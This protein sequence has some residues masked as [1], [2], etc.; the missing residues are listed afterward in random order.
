MSHP[1]TWRGH[2][3]PAACLQTRFTSRKLSH[4]P[5]SYTVIG[6]ET[7]IV[8]KL[9]HERELCLFE[10]VFSWVGQQSHDSPAASP[11]RPFIAS[12]PSP[13]AMSQDM[14]GLASSVFLH[15]QS[16]TVITT[17]CC[18]CCFLDELSASVVCWHLAGNKAKKK[19]GNQRWGGGGY[20]N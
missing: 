4:R 18:V 19:N 3:Q 11:D 9:C 7:E 6:W 16:Q 17:S 13:C 1:L 20:T 5:F 15:D 10:V 14:G 2:W 8:A 12:R